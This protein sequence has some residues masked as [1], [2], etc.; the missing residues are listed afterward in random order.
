[1]FKEKFKYFRRKKPKPDFKSVISLQNMDTRHFSNVK[2]LNSFVNLL[3]FFYESL[4]T[5]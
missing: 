4:R 5:R 1:M 2:L 3:K